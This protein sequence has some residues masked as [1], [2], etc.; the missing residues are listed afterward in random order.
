[1]RRHFIFA[2]PEI[3]SE[4]AIPYTSASILTGYCCALFHRFP[5]KADAWNTTQAGLLTSDLASAEPSHQLVD[6]GFFNGYLWSF[7]VAGPWRILT[8]LPYSP[9]FSGTWTVRLF[10]CN[11]YIISHCDIFCKFFVKYP[12]NMNTIFFIKNLTMQIGCDIININVYRK[13]TEKWKKW[14]S[15]VHTPTC[16]V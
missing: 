9:T 6:S 3:V 1:M 11:V 5:A 16:I 7:T 14:H 12:G 10:N 2:N 8:A 13:L 4:D 15:Y